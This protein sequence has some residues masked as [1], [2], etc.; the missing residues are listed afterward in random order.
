MKRLIF[1]VFLLI[2]FSLFGGYAYFSRY[3]VLHP[4]DGLFFV[5]SDLEDVTLNVWKISEEDF[6]E[7][8]F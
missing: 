2:S 1:L 4:D 6:F 8:S 5:I 7:S 3:P